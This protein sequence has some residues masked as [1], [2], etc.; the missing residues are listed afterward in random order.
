MA[1]G[2]V[3]SR[4]TQSLKQQDAKKINIPG[5]EVAIDEAR[6]V[7][8]VQNIMDLK[9][10]VKGYLVPGK[11]EVICMVLNEKVTLEKGVME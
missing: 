3:N 7:D 9:G 1:K 5:V 10:H 11:I 6:N 4:Q 2:D 8:K